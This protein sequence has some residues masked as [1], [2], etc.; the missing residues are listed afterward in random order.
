MSVTNKITRKAASWTYKG[1][2]IPF[3]SMTPSVERTMADA[4]DST[5]YDSGS[6]S[7]WPSQLEVKVGMKFKVE[8]RY[9]TSTIP[10]AIL[11]DLYTG[12]SAAA[13]VIK[14]N[15]ST[16]F[17]H[18]NFDISNFEAKIQVDDIV[19]YSCDLMSNGLWV[20]GS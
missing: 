5:D 2:T 4:T 10:S 6:D 9:N 20:S 1:A 16:I 14:L 17:G 3:T 13:V 15:P 19:T 11:T 7:L 8:G 12:A 18:G